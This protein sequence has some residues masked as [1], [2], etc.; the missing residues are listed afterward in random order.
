[1][2]HFKHTPLVKIKFSKKKK[3]TFLLNFETK[4]KES[5]YVCLTR[6]KV[7]PVEP[8]AKGFC[9]AKVSYPQNTN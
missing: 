8:K 1:M 3:K 2:N 4:D 9:D 6:A 7:I 5:I